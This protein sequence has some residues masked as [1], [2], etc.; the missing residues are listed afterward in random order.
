MGKPV[1]EE[2]VIELINEALEGLDNFFNSGEATKDIVIDGKGNKLTFKN[3][4]QFNLDSIGYIHF[5]NYF[6]MLRE[7]TSDSETNYRFKEEI[8]DRDLFQTV[9]N[10]NTGRGTRFFMDGNPDSSN[11]ELI[12]SEKDSKGFR[13]NNGWFIPENLETYETKAE[14]QANGVVGWFQTSDGT[15]KTTR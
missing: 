6:Y 1:S 5:R 13:M 8:S 4:G 7:T 12:A 11:I 3:F 10:K 2:R 9:S 15:I 14:A